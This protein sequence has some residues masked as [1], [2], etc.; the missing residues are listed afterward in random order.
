[1]LTAVLTITGLIVV[2][3]ASFVISLAEFQDANHYIIRQAIW[4]VL[5][6]TLLII[7]MRTDY[8]IYRAM[9]VPIMLAT[10]GALVLVLVAGV[11]G[12]GARRWLGYG[13]FS[14][15]PAEFAKLAVILY[16][17]AWLSAKGDSIRTLEGGF[18]PFVVIISSIGL[19]IMLEP[20]LGTTLIIMAIAVVMFWVAGATLPQMLTLGAAGFACVLLLAT[21]EGYRADR[22]STF[23]NAGADPLGH[24]FQTLQTLIAMGNGGITGLGLGA[25]RAKFF[26]IPESHTDGVFAILG[27]ELGV[28]ATTAV[29]VLYMTL[30]VRGFQVARRSRDDYG[31]LVATGITTWITVQALL[32][33]GGITRVIPLTGVPLPFLSYG[34][35]ALAAVMLAIGVL[36]SISRFGSDRGGY[37]ERG[38]RPPGG[39]G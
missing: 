34:G 27:E 32:N 35:S 2:Y 1:M 16:L 5:G 17:A 39:R 19:L 25:S 4:A 33:I 9:S 15:Q 28:V 23:L 11:T 14:I 6:V 7:A 21:V 22:L 37:G 20:N 24:G 38:P 3:S 12:G 36:V 10:I 31:Q 13:D 8:R 29:L 26:Y 18:L 30:M